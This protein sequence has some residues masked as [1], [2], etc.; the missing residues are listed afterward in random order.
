MIL[1]NYWKQQK[2]DHLH[3]IVCNTESASLKNDCP[4]LSSRDSEPNLCAKS[5]SALIVE[6]EGFDVGE[7][8]KNE[9][10]NAKLNKAKVNNKSDFKKSKPREEIK[11][12]KHQLIL[13]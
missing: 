9:D 7:E 5:A 6:P 8:Y 10:N 11:K 12:I 1:L 2:N 13:R 4:I 3:L